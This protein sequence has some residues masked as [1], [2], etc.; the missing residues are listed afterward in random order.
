MIILS[1]PRAVN[2]AVLTDCSDGVLVEF[3]ARAGY[4]GPADAGPYR[5][6]HREVVDAPFHVVRDAIADLLGD[7]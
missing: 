1:Q 2:R 7:D 6:L 4:R 3:F 5:L